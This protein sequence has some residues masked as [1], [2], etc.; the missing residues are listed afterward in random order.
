[1]NIPHKNL[2]AYKDR[3][4]CRI[5][6]LK[7]LKKIWRRKKLQFLK[8]TEKKNNLQTPDGIAFHNADDFKTFIL[9]TGL[10]VL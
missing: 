10:Y 6:I 8:I 2:F 4:I 3:A 1:M 5:L 9:L 7:I